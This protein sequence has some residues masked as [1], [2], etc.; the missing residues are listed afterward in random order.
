MMK[1]LSSFLLLLALLHLCTRTSGQSS[2]S[3][4]SDVTSVLRKSGKFTTFI[5]LLKSTQMDEPINSQLQKTSSQGF[6]VF[7]PT[8]SAFSDLQTVPNCEQPVRTEAG[9]D[10][11]DFPLN[12]VSNGTQVNITTGLVNTTVDST[13]YSDGQLAVYEIGDVLLSPGILG[14]GAPA[15]AP[16]PPKAK[17]ASPPNSQAPSRST[18]ASVDSSGATGLPHYAPMVASIGVAVLAALSLCL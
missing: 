14:T 9:N 18:T 11:V 7:A 4:A 12:V 1:Q 15:P 8:D 13:V 16:L 10:A 6:T 3:G 2:P 17:K 5:G